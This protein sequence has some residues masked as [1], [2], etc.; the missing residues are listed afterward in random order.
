MRVKYRLST[1]IM[2]L[3]RK[4]PFRIPLFNNLIRAILKIRLF[5]KQQ[6]VNFFVV[7]N[8]KV[9]DEWYKNKKIFF[10]LGVIR[11]GTTFLSHFLNETINN[12][13]VKH[14]AIPEDFWAYAKAFNNN[15]EALKYVNF[16]YYEI[17]CRMHKKQIEVYGEINPF[18]RRHVLPLKDVFYFA[19]FFHIVR[20][21]RDVVRSIMSKSNLSKKDPIQKFILPSAK[22]K[23]QKKWSS[24]SRF[25]KVCWW[26]QA[27]NK[28]LRENIG[29]IVQFE[30]L[31]R[32]YD[33]FQK[34]ILDYLDLKIPKEK[35]QEYINQ[36]TNRT[37]K[38]SF[39]HWTNWTKKQMNVFNKIC[40]EEML[41][42]GYDLEK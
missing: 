1:R 31:I 24:M 18:L 30:K 23:W 4:I 14:E 21:G 41:K 36:I 40:G 19:L 9:V 33:Y 12:A 13:E 28:Y 10:G 5:A 2:R 37:K 17:Y 27:E 32:D 7:S 35:W 26:W 6:Y 39:P 11:S 3:Y 25:E 8:K 34:N 42:C 15:K 38:F 29:H 16:R 22:D 20:D